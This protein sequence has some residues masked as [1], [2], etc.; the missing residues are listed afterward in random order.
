MSDGYT[1]A[2]LGLPVVVVVQK[3]F[4]AAARIQAKILGAPDLPICA[5]PAS[6]PGSDISPL[7]S[8]LANDVIGILRR[9]VPA[10][11]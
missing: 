10:K 8:D 6:P 7:A 9:P 5:Y 3:V 4:E 1:I 11:R 2:K